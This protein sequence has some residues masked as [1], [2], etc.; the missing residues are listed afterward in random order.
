LRRTLFCLDRCCPP[1][2][3]QIPNSGTGITCTTP[4]Q[5]WG[6]NPNPPVTYLNTTGDVTAHSYA[7][8]N[9]S[10]AGN[11]WFYPA[12]GPNY[13][14]LVAPPSL[15]STITWTLPSTPPPT[16]SVLVFPGGT[17][18]QL[19]Y[20]TFG[21][22]DVQSSYSSGVF[23]FSLTNTPPFTGPATFSVSS[24]SVLKL[25]SDGAGT[26]SVLITSAGSGLAPIIVVSNTD[27]EW[28]R[29]PWKIS[30]AAG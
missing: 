30:T 14:Q 22:G 15:P 25:A 28:L 8:N 5:G 16:N 11:V 29:Y 20:G 12:S 21:T 3:G 19:T 18:N 26:N 4:P 10:T 2:N 27:T 23:T 1:V 17:S 9:A 7:S 24:A 6:T 13:L